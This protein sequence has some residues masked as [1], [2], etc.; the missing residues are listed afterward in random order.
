MSKR[1]FTVEEA[2]DI[3]QQDME[4]WMTVLTAKAWSALMQERSERNQLHDGV[5]HY[6]VW[7]GGQISEWVQNYAKCQYQGY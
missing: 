1:T 4:T 7:R 6:S 2:L 5:D 3:Q